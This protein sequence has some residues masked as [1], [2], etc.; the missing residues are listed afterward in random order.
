M[1]LFMS[2]LQKEEVKLFLFLQFF[3]YKCVRNSIYWVDGT[4]NGLPNTI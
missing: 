3:S 4:P 2:L 1:I